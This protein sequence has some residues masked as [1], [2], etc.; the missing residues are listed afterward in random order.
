M[1]APLVEAQVPVRELFQQCP[2]YDA[3]RRL[4]LEEVNEYMLQTSVLLRSRLLLGELVQ[5]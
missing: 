2:L 3:F 4:V 1:R 5:T